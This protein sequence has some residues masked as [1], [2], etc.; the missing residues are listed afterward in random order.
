MVLILVVEVGQLLLEL[1][2]FKLKVVMV[3]Q[4][5]HQVLTE[6][7][8]QEPVVEV[9][10]LIYVAVQELLVQEQEEQV[11]VDQVVQQQVQQVQEMVVQQLLIQAAVVVEHQQQGQ[12]QDL[13]VV[14]QAVQE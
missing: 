10:G 11:V 1:V 9:E 13:V 2:L 5:L 14:A 8:L 6:P 12:V 7:Q 4:E 3:E